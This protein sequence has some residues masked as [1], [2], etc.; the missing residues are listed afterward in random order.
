[1]SDNISSF[2]QARFFTTIYH[3]CG[4][5]Y[6]G[7]GNHPVKEVWKI[8]AG[9]CLCQQMT[10]SNLE[11]FSSYG[12]WMLCLHMGH[13]AFPAIFPLSLLSFEDWP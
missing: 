2:N 8:G 12:R 9:Y 13:T 6:K 10:V 5:V 1:M 3:R 4:L 7:G 11:V